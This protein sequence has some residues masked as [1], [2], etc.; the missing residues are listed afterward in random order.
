M[1]VTVV[2]IIRRS[3]VRAPLAPPAVR[4]R[5]PQR[6]ELRRWRSLENVGETLPGWP[7]GWPVRAALSAASPT[8]C[9]SD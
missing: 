3:W 5:C 6:Q 2:L 4:G 8:F 7:D 1:Q 9:L